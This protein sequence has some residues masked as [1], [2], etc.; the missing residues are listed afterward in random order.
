[1]SNTRENLLEAARKLFGQ[2]GIKNT[3]MN[4]I[5]LVSQ[6]G[7]RT[8]YTY[9]K[10]KD[11]VLD[12]VIAEEM[13]YVV[14]SLDEVMQ[15]D[16]NA[17]DKFVAYVITRMNAVRLAVERNGSL[18]SEFFRDVVRVE[19]VRRKLEKIEIACLERIFEDG[20]KNGIFDISDVKQVAVFAHFVMRGLDVPY[21]RGTFD[22]KG[23]DKDSALKRKT[24]I[25]LKGL[26]KTD[27]NLISSDPS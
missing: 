18:R 12:A 26:V 25:I 24:Y 19:L 7:R 5:A 15:R 3:T 6:K 1:M 17:L 4:D 23:I 21:I 10:N 27:R 22:E 8:V 14:A 9:F 20:V 13:Q 11:E 16:L 2:M